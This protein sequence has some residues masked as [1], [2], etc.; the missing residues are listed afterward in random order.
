VFLGLHEKILIEDL[1]LRRLAF[2]FF[3]IVALLPTDS[4]A[5]ERIMTPTRGAS[6]NSTRVPEPYAREQ[7]GIEC[8]GPAGYRFTYSD[9]ATFAGVAIEF[10]GRRF[11]HETMNWTPTKSGLGSRLEWHLNNGVPV[12]VIVSRWRR[13]PSFK[14]NEDVEVQEFLIVRTMPTGACAIGQFL[15]SMPNALENA[16]GYAER[17]WK[18]WR[19]SNKPFEHPISEDDSVKALDSGFSSVEMLDHNGSIVELRRDRSGTIEIKYVE[20]RPTLKVAPGAVLFRG[21]EHGGLVRGEAFVFKPGCPPAGYS[22]SGKREDGTLVLQG[23]LP[24]RGNGCEIAAKA[25]GGKIDRLVFEVEPLI[26]SPLKVSMKSLTT[27]AQCGKCMSATV[28]EMEGVDSEKASIKAEILETNIKDYCE[29]WHFEKAAVNACIADYERDKGAVQKASADCLA[30]TI[31]PS[32]GGKYRFA[33]MVDEPKFSKPSW[34]DEATGK[35]ECD[36][37][38]CNSDTASYQFSLLCPS[39]I[40]GWPRTN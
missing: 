9:F 34:I 23:A 39:V 31:E 33:K 25:K 26:A 38:A 6:C 13:A 10:K 24:R 12:F 7:G 36:A 37:Q 11:S 8:A 17:L 21:N 14:T 16:R 1:K 22:V 3:A 19:C 32:S 20:P 40:S 29:N 28:V 35:P 30:K 18:D 5:L 4:F 15:S 27:I 2:A